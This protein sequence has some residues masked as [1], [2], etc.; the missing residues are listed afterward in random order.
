MKW[1]VT[2]GDGIILNDSELIARRQFIGEVAGVSPSKWYPDYNIRSFCCE[3]TDNINGL[4]ITGHVGEVAAICNL[5][6]VLQF[7]FI[8]ANTCIWE[9]DY[10]KRILSYLMKSRRNI[11]LW[12]AKQEV[13][14]ENDYIM[15]KTNELENMG[16]FGFPT[17]KSER[18]L[19]KN[20]KKGF[21]QALEVSFDIVSMIYTD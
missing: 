1:V 8:V 13:S 18:M 12:Y 10:E 17:S 11:K 6:S 16:N 3:T 5:R 14:L 19:F 21:M 7:D 15:R 4:F 9:K 2:N 20:R